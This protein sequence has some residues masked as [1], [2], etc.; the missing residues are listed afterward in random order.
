[1][2]KLWDG[3]GIIDLED[4][5][6][7]KSEHYVH[8]VWATKQREPLIT[9]EIERSV[10]RCIVDLTIGLKCP[11]R[12]INGMPDHVHLVVGL[13]S[14][15]CSS[16]IMKQVKGV[17]S[18]MIND[19]HDHQQYFRWQQGYYIRSV[20]LSHLKGVIAYVDNQKQHHADGT[21]HAEWEDAGDDHI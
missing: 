3:F 15:V 7:S 5:L 4:T 9:P 19:L 16:R 6:S 21:I 10:Y 18:A 11:V 8:F 20:S 1:M 14:D 13:H 12:A 17:S 2:R